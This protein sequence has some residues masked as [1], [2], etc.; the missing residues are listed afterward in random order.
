VRT[1]ARLLGYE[2]AAELL[3]DTLDE[4]AAADKKLTKL[5]ETVINVEAA[6]E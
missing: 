6:K 1:F 3:Q 4:G 2:G 5:A